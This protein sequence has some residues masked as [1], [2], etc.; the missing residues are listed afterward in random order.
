MGARDAGAIRTHPDRGRILDRADLGGGAAPRCAQPAPRSRPGL[1]HGSHPTTCLCL[2]W[3]RLHLASGESLLDYGCGSGILAIAGARLGAGRVVGTDVDPQ[4]IRASEDNARANDVAATFVLP[5]ALPPGSFDVVVANILANP[6]TLLAPALALR[7]RLGGRI[8]LSGILEPQAAAVAAAYARWF[9]IGPWNARDGWVLAGERV[10]R[11]LAACV[12]WGSRDES[13]CC[14]ID[15]GMRFRMQASTGRLTR[16]KSW[17]KNS[18]RAVRVARPSFA[19]RSRSSRCA[20]DR[21]AAVT[22]A[23]YSTVASI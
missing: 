16:R 2:E 18:T 22:A 1:R 6:L 14:A 4:A 9:N 17:P 23:P 3:M 8:A 11:G 5:D 7:V 12:N 13:E 21:F 19:S 10:G 20:T 15:W